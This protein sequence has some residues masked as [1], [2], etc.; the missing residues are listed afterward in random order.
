V[1]ANFRITERNGQEYV[2]DPIRKKDVILSP[3]EWVRQNNLHQLVNELNYPPSLISVEKEIKVNG[4]SKRYDIL[5]YKEGAPWMIVECKREEIKL[6]QNILQQTLAYASAL[7]LKYLAL[8]N[9]RE[10]ISFNIYEDKW[11]TGFPDY[12]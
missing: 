9:G 5:V 8:S 10:S 1:Q 2:F 6:S 12:N 4:Q 7:K 3:E 11:A